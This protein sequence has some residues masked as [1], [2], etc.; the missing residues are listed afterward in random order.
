MEDRKLNMLAP[1]GKTGYGVVGFNILRIMRERDW[2]VSL[3]THGSPNGRKDS[4]QETRVISEAVDRATLFH[5]D[6][7]CINIW[8]QHDMAYKIGNGP[9]IGYPFF[10]L[11]TFNEMERHHLNYPDKLCVTSEWA[12]K[13]VLDNE[14]SCEED[15]YVVPLGIDNK[16]FNVLD[17]LNHTKERGPTVFL[18]CGKWEIRKGHDFLI[19][20]FH[21]AFGVNDDVELWMLPFNPFLS[22]GDQNNWENMYLDT[23]MGRAGKV[24]IFPWQENHMDVSNIMRKADCGLFPSRAEGWNLELL[25]MMAIGKPVI[26]TNYSAHTEFCDDNN[27]LLIEIDDV[28]PAY[29]GKWFFEQGNWADIGVPQLKQMCEY[30]RQVH[31]QGQSPAEF[32]NE[33]G[34]ETGK[35]FTWDNTVDKIEE[36]LLDISK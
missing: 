20:M 31:V 9:Y 15:V 21:K 4:A 25:E 33:A 6:A 10:E 35:K 2:D 24:K 16:I 12:K 3:F 30:M 27:C 26:A 32:V 8:H 23:P 17:P 36:M 13:V 7:P 22:S 1:I 34:I 18:N 28:V 14:V 29:D 11:D 19:D 5:Y